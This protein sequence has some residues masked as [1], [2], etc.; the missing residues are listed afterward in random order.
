M[1]LLKVTAAAE[2]L[3]ASPATVYRLIYSGRLTPHYIGT[4]KIRPRVR[5]AE[6]EL[7]RY[8]RGSAA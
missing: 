4:G 3:D 8:I 2:R 7:D 1:R 6:D 5:V